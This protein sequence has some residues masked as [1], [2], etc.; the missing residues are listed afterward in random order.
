MTTHGNFNKKVKKFNPNPRSEKCCKDLTPKQVK[1]NAQNRIFEIKRWETHLYLI[2]NH[3][4]MCF[5]AINRY[6]LPLF[7]FIKQ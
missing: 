2:L 5:L 6:I 1:K 7:L 3:I 4:R